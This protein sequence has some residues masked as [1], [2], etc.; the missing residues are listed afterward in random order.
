MGYIH[1]IVSEIVP[2][3]SRKSDWSLASFLRLMARG[4]SAFI[5]WHELSRQRH[6]LAQLDDR[7]LR[8]IGVSRTDVERECAK[9]PWQN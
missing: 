5:R 6:Q 4:V 7:M 2:I 9:F 3:Q 1:H 8:D